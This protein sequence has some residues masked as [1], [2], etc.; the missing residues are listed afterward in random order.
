MIDSIY[1]YE[2]TAKLLIRLGFIFVLKDEAQQLLYLTFQTAST[3]SDQSPR[4]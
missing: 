3:K 1:S 2:W 4:L